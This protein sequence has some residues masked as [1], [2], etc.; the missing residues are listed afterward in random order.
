MLREV[1]MRI[2]GEKADRPERSSAEKLRHLVPICSICN[3]GLLDHRYA[4]LATS[5]REGNVAKMLSLVR[6]HR[7]AELIALQEWNPELNA[8]VAYAITGPHEGG[9]VVAIKN[10]YELFESDEVYLSEAVTSEDIGS[11]G[12]SL[13]DKAWLFL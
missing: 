12:A 1:F 3:K 11:I 6:A 4:Q 8:L 7:W 5:F 13:N 10:S 9:M 2:A